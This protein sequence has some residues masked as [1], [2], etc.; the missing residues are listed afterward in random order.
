MNKLWKFVHFLLSR[1]KWKV[2][3]KFWRFISDKIWT[4]EVAD[5]GLEQSFLPSINNHKISNAFVIPFGFWERNNWET[6]WR[7]FVKVIPPTPIYLDPQNNMCA[8]WHV[9]CAMWYVTCC[10]TWHD[11]SFFLFKKKKYMS[12]VYAKSQHQK[13]CNFPTIQMVF[14]IFS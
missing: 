10:D 3:S 13:L 6:E 7:L 8:M 14:L 5:N 1:T 9:T 12:N 2:I 4:A 11:I